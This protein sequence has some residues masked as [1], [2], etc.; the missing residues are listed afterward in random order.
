MLNG[1]VVFI[2][3]GKQIDDLILLAILQNQI[4]NAIAENKVDTSKLASVKHFENLSSLSEE[5]KSDIS[6]NL[7]EFLFDDY[8]KTLYTL[9]IKEPDW[10]YARL[11]TVGTG[12]VLLSKDGLLYTKLKDDKNVTVDSSGAVTFTD[13]IVGLNI[14]PAVQ[15]FILK[16]EKYP[17]V[18]FYANYYSNTADA[19]IYR[20]SS[21]IILDSST[22]TSQYKIVFASYNVKAAKVTFVEK[23]LT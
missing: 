21:G 9:L 15:N 4:Q 5:E 7:Y 6:N 3:L 13:C 20:F 22:E 16:S 19:I 14:F 23:V 12:Y 10:K 1:K 18:V 2:N 8:S 17:D 11:Y